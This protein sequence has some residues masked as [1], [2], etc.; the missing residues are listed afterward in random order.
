MLTLVP[1]TLTVSSSVVVDATP[2]Q[3]WALVS[4]PS[5]TPRWSSENTGAS[6]T[7][8]LGVGDEFDGTNSRRS[9]RWVT[10]SVVTASEP[11]VR[12]A[13]R[14][15]AIGIGSPRVETSNASWEY[16]LEPAADGTRVTET[17]HDDRRWPDLLARVFDRIATRTSFPQFQQRNL[18]RSLQR[19]KTV[20]EAG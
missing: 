2:A 8:T 12:F 6:T 9:F 1:R 11:D 20:V 16:R 10:R 13:F 15:H 17:W 4:D 3:V 19:L 7:G 14:V 5:Q 18:E